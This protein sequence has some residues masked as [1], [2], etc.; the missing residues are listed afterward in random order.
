MLIAVSAFGF[1][2]VELLLRRKPS[3]DLHTLSLSFSKFARLGGIIA[4]ITG[5]Y[6]WV[7]IGGAPGWLIVKIVLFLWFVFS[8]IFV[9]SRYISKR[10]EILSAQSSREEELSRVNK[11]IV[12]YSYINLLVFILIVFLAVFKPF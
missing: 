2:M 10:G 9:G 11:A 3:N 4:L 12:N 7:D 8:G 6:N 5:I 1:P